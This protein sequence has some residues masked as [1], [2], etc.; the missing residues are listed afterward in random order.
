MRG[1]PTARLGLDEH[2]LVLAH[3]IHDA[4]AILPDRQPGGTHPLRTLQGPD[5][6]RA[7]GIR[8]EERRQRHLGIAC[9][10]AAGAATTALVSSGL[11]PARLLEGRTALDPLRVVAVVSGG[12]P[13]PAQFEAVRA[14]G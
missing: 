9:V 13:D 8:A 12:N 14:Q 6:H 4:L 5:W 3:S 2:D 10:E 11:L 7:A 1:F